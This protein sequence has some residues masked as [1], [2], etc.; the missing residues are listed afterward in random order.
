[1][2]KSD[3]EIELL[4]RVNDVASDAHLAVM[5]LAKPGMAEFQLESSFLHHCYYNGGCR[6]G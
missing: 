4:Q 2:H 1:M 6:M 3:A 5:R